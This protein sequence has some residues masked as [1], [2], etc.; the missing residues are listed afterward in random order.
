[1]LLIEDFYHPKRV[2]TLHSEL[3]PD[4]YFNPVSSPNRIYQVISRLR[5]WAEG[6]N[7]PL[8]IKE[9]N[10]YYWA[11]VLAG[12]G[13]LVREEKTLASEVSPNQTLINRLQEQR[14]EEFSA[15]QACDSLGL[16]RSSFNRF[17]KWAIDEGVLEK[18]GQ[19]SATHYRLIKNAA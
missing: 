19:S 11:R 8:S 5:Q 1:M 9:D 6:T 4:S 3:F 14:I 12:L 10:G 2:G 17:A 13:V 15:K 7:V 16:S 18:R